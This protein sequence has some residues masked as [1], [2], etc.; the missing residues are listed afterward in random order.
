MRTTLLDCTLRDGGYYNAWDFSSELITDYLAA[1]KAAQVDV[2]ELGF[3]F[4]GNQGFKGACAYTT[5]DF[6]RGLTV[7]EGLEVAVMANGADLCGPMGREAALERLFPE[8]AA[9]T[10]VSIARFACHYHELPDVLP[11]TS[12]LVDRGYRVGVNLM[13]IADRTEQEIRELGAMANEW[14]L[15]VLYFAD[16][17]GGMTPEDVV[18]I[19]GLLREHW[20]GAIGIHTHDNMGLALANTLRAQ[21]EGVSWLDATVTGMGRGPGNAR[22]EELAIEAEGFRDRRA[23]LVPL[24]T[25]IRRHFAPMKAHFGWGTNPYYYLAGKY[26]IHPTYIQEMLGDARYDEE[27]ILAVIEHLRAE[28]GKKFSFNTLEGARQF[29]HGEPRGT[30]APSEMMEGREVLILGT[31]P[32]VAAHRP[33]LEAYIRRAQPLVMALNTQSAIDPALIDLR[34]AC[35]PV[36]LLADAETHAALPQPLVT[37]VSMLP[38]SL[39]AALGDKELLDFGLGIEPGRFEFH[40]THCIAPTSLVLAYALA[41]TTSGRALRIL[42]AGFDGYPAGDPRNDET[43]AILDAYRSVAGEDLLISVTPTRHRLQSVSVY[44]A[45]L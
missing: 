18:R 23:D 4:L 19:V 45:V 22:T 1:M 2:V 17:M 29:Y 26:G 16:S 8:A 36:R 30:W 32:G 35:H 27:D 5:D 21:A 6:L 37:P 41:V 12:W 39:V 34:I 40:P 7:P 9:H 14:P 28:G 10:P 13:Q 44:A 25:L 15:E 11:A 42:M 31:G 38:E 20:Q 24:M 3:R 43:A 33:A